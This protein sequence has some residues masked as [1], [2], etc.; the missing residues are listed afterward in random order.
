MRKTKQLIISF[1]LMAA[2]LFTI[3]MMPNTA[4]AY[5]QYGLSA[6]GVT[7]LDGDPIAATGYIPITATG[8]IVTVKNIQP[9]G[10]DPYPIEVYLD[11]N[12]VRSGLGIDATYT[13]PFSSSYAVG[14]NIVYIFDF[15][16]AGGTIN[17]WYVSPNSD[18]STAGDHVH[19]FVHCVIYDPTEDMDG[20]EGEKCSCGAVRNL[21]K[22]SADTVFYR[23]MYKKVDSA[24]AGTP[25][26]LEFNRRNTFP[27]ELFDRM[28]AKSDCDFVIRF[29]GDDNKVYEMYIPAGSLKGLTLTD[30]C[31]GYGAFT[32][33]FETKEIF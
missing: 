20:L 25:M 33:L 1:V 32:G 24:Y 15:T 19:N 14:G 30:D 10:G 11:E 16:S 26:V 13:L 31:Y 4:L 8:D 27:K 23:N 28:A 9:S 2:V 21:S 12:L 22:I 17:F 3:V 18:S 5:V 6:D 29:R 7:T